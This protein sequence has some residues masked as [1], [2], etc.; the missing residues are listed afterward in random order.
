MLKRKGFTLVELLVVIA[1]IGI[2]I[3]M[4]LP[5]IQAVREAARRMSCGNKMRQIGLALHNYESAHQNLPAGVV[6]PEGSGGKWGPTTLLL[7][8]LEQENAAQ[9]LGAGNDNTI[10]SRATA[11]G[12]RDVI[13][14]GYSFGRC[15]SDSNQEEP[16]NCGRRGLIGGATNGEMSAVINYVYANNALQDPFTP[17]T[18]SDPP[19]LTVQSSTVATGLFHDRESTLASM[20]DGTTNVIM[21]SERS[22]TVNDGAI[23][24]GNAFVSA[25]LLFGSRAGKVD[26][27]LFS[28]SIGINNPPIKQAFD[29]NLQRNDHLASS[30]HLAGVNV[31]LGDASTHFLSDGVD[32]ISFNQLVN[33]SDGTV[34][35]NN[36]F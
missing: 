13:T 28:T 22:T 18:P 19:I 36:P 32:F 27:V 35:E 8:F 29:I 33:I 21:I 34:I 2:L 1:I 6:N 7:P 16:L 23:A 25:G 24:N 9:V 17:T 20:V 5:A 10:A 31:C 15:P 3:G 11:P 4:L 12:V 26:D 14:T 30:L